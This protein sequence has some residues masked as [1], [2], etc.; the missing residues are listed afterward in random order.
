MVHTSLF[1]EKHNDFVIGRLHLAYFATQVLLFRALM[2]PASMA[3]KIDPSSPLRRYF[4]VA[5]E[6]AGLFCA[7]MA[8]LTNDY[9]KAFWGRRK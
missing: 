7:F 3:A 4:E 2:A 8:G 5:L 1:G 9:V 6:Q